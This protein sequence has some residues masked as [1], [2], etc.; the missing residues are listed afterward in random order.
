MGD[1]QVSQNALQLP[2]QGALLKK[3]VTNT[4]GI[5]YIS[6]GLVFG[7]DKI[8]AF[9]L[10]GIEPTNKNVI[11]GSYPFVRPLLM[12]VK[13]KPG[14]MAK[15]FIDYVMTVGQLIVADNDYVPAAAVK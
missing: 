7:S 1:K 15:S 14:L 5:G 13:G 9:D 4:K 6:S 2:S 12:V 11:N 8:K 10:E 3:L